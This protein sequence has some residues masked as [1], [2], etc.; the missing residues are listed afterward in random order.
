[1]GYSLAAH[2]SPVHPAPSVLCTQVRRKPPQ[3]PRQVTVTL[4]G[5]KEDQGHV[6]HLPF[7]LILPFRSAL[8]GASVLS[9]VMHTCRGAWGMHT[10][11][12]LALFRPGAALFVRA[13]CMRR[14][15]SACVPLMVL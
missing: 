7:K 14:G 1:M 15:L 3:V 9:P 4:P 10:G 6:S 13:A 11:G 12:E 8:Q 2:R 5:A